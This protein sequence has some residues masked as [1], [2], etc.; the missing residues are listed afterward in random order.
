MGN[1]VSH[2]SQYMRA[3]KL[4]EI[5]CKEGGVSYSTLVSKEKNTKLNVLRGLV[6]YFSREL[7][8]HPN[9]T[10]NLIGRQRCNVITMCQRYRHYIRIG[11]KA[12]KELCEKV[13][14]SIDTSNIRVI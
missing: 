6:Y 14:E 4:I 1:A 2:T 3:D 9:I 11:D 8:I 13:R 12:T 7:K 5:V 10:A